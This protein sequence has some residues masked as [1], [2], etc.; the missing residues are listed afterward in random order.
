MVT[1][2]YIKK[3]KRSNRKIHGVD[4]P[5]GGG[6][7]AVCTAVVAMDTNL[8][9]E[10]SFD[11]CYVRN[12]TDNEAEGFCPDF[13]ETEGYNNRLRGTVYHHARA[14]VRSEQTVRA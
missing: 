12:G 1:Y 9:G 13:Q 5:C 6:A 2:E 4:S 8:L 14:R 3:N 11:D 7:R 10:L